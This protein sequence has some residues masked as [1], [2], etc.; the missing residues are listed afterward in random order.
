[1]E[2]RVVGQTNMGAFNEKMTAGRK[3]FLL[4]VAI[5]FAACFLV[6]CMSLFVTFPFIG[7]LQLAGLLF[8]G[9]VYATITQTK[10]TEQAFPSQFSKAV[11]FSLALFLA[12]C[13]VYFFQGKFNFLDVLALSCA[14]LLPVSIAASWKVFISI[15]KNY[16][17]VWYY[18]QDTPADSNFVYL[19]NTPVKVEVVI[20]GTKVSRLKTTVPT[21]LEL[22]TAIYHLIKTQDPLKNG[23]NTFFDEGQSPFGWIFYT[24]KMLSKSYL[25]PEET[26]FE[27]RIKPNTVIYAERIR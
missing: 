15:P 5:L 2:K 19:E 25:T 14:F 23:R 10:F 8:L 1:M 11:Y 4:F 24:K 22:G 9:A 12:F 3:G 6:G 17:H 13:V 26:I 7:W 20:D 21:T 18:S 16:K 27:N